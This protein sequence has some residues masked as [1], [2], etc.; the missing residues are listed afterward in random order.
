MEVQC[1]R[2]RRNGLTGF[3]GRLKFNLAG[4]RASESPS[5][6][7][8]SNDRLASV[9]CAGLG[10]HLLAT[11]MDIARAHCATGLVSRTK[12][13][14]C[15]HTDTH[16]LTERRPLGCT[17]IA[18]S[19]NGRLTQRVGRRRRVSAHKTTR[20]RPA[21]SRLGCAELPL[22]QRPSRLG[23]SGSR[24]DALRPTVQKFWPRERGKAAVCGAPAGQWRPPCTGRHFWTVELCE[25][26]WRRQKLTAEQ[27]RTSA[28][29][30]DTQ[31]IRT[32]FCCCCCCECNC[33]AAAAA[34]AILLRR[35][36]L[37]V[38]SFAHSFT[39]SG[40]PLGLQP[41]V[42]LGKLA[43]IRRARERTQHNTGRQAG[44]RTHI[45]ETQALELSRQRSP[46]GSGRIDGVYVFQ[47]R[48]SRSQFQLTGKLAHH[49]LES[50][51]AA[52]ATTTTTATAPY[53]E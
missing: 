49:K 20:R 12:L 29:E 44:R 46:L 2:E 13:L 38:R 7:S 45:T 19:R 16:K 21:P 39:R 5:F 8:F 53:L 50:C 41:V 48:S 9:G 40:R 24:R 4:S 43:A 31:K 27:V 18:V 15:T 33:C 34:A 42:L 36:Q 37:F 17:R 22:L 52:T 3:S 51:T 26:S 14:P 1:Y 10:S 28:S 35:F 23:L 25:K 11:M 47:S 30:L 32:V 6:S